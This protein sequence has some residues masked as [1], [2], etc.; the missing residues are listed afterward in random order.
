[1][2]KASLFAVLGNS[3]A[4]ANMCLL[5]VCVAGQYEHR[6]SITGCPLSFGRQNLQLN[7]LQAFGILTSLFFLDMLTPVVA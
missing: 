5:Q 3:L 4:G 1:M 2:N 7:R 6:L